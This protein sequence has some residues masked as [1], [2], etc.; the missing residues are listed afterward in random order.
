MAELIRETELFGT[1]IPRLEGLREKGRAA[2]R[3]PTPK[4]E[5]WKYTRLHVLKNGDFVPPASKFLAELSGEDGDGCGCSGCHDD[6]CCGR[7]TEHHCCGESCGCEK[8]DGK[9]TGHCCCGHCHGNRP[10]LPFA[11]YPLHFDNGQFVPVYPALPRGV[12]VMTLMKLLSTAK[13]IIFSANT[14]T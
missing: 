11:A 4:T 12:E 3:L 10:E 5:A 2:F 7:E 13:K 8:G 6:G 9:D 1:D 14:L